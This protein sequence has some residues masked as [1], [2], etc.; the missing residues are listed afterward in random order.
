MTVV[1]IH[2][3]RGECQKGNRQAQQWNGVPELDPH[4]MALRSIRGR[5]PTIEKVGPAWLLSFR[6]TCSPGSNL[7]WQWTVRW[8]PA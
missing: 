3:G 7:G 5:S 8:E 2:H 4:S 6:A 1:A